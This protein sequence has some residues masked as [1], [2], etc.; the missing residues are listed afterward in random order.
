MSKLHWFK[1]QSEDLPRFFGRIIPYACLFIVILVLA[2]TIGLGRTDLASRGLYLIIPVTLAAVIAIW[3]PDLFSEGE[4]SAASKFTVG[5]RHFPHLVLLF[6]LLY[7]VTLCLLVGNETRPLSYFCLVA[8]MAGLI[9]VEVLSIGQEQSGRRSIILTQI[10]F[11]S[12]N[13]IMGQT[14]KLPLFFGGTDILGH[15]RYIETIIAEGHVTPL[16]ES[17]QYFPLFHVFD[18]VGMLVT[19][20]GLKMSYFIVGGLSF[21]VSIPI[22]YLLVNWLTRN[23]KVS[24][25]A[26]LIY[27][28]SQ[29][30]IF[31]G[32]YMV[33]RTMAYLL[34]LLA[35]YLLLRGRGNIQF[36]GIAIFL[37]LPLVLMH[38]A[39]LVEV[40]GILLLII[41]IELVLHRRSRYIGYT[42]PML[43]VAAYISYWIYQCGPFIDP[44]IRSIVATAEPASLPVAGTLIVPWYTYLAKHCD[45]SIIAFLAILGIIGQLSRG[46]RGGDLANIFALLSLV[47]LIFYLPGLSAYFT[48][49]FLGYRLPLLLLPFIAF[50]AGSAVLLFIRQWR[51]NAKF[52]RVWTILGLGLVVVYCFCSVSI[53][54][55]LTDFNIGKVVGNH[56]RGYFTEVELSSFSFIAEHKEETRVYSDY[57]ASRYISGYLALPSSAYLDVF[58]IDSIGEGYFLFRQGEYYSRGQLLF[59]LKRSEEGSFRRP[60]LKA[61]KLGENEDP[62]AIWEQQDKVFSN[63]GVD[64][65]YKPG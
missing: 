57:Q 16:M 24:L 29:D 44:I 22:V 32:M 55:N 60:V 34:C 53:L 39:T 43:F 48:P 27:S 20:M 31:G 11:L 13:L 30:A 54:G 46:K 52:R 3:K 9:L 1:H 37:I 18:A 61:Y 21:V 65:Y 59:Y 7:L 5:S 25:I 64:I 4:T 12:L 33:T 2:I 10:I 26:V 23:V 6:I 14:L 28:I 49:L 58:D 35:L 38:Q 41:I 40:T 56:N 8:V 17:Y 45:Y 15:M 19:G 51:A 63:G 47:S 42:Y 62:G 50:A 36:R